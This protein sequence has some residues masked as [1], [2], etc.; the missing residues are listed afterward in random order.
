M[1]ESDLDDVSLDP[2]PQQPSSKTFG[3]G[4]RQPL[5]ELKPPREALEGPSA[6]LVKLRNRVTNGSG[7]ADFLQAADFSVFSGIE[8]VLCAT[9]LKKLV[10]ECNILIST[11]MPH[12]ITQ[13]A[14]VFLN[15]FSLMHRD[16]LM[17]NYTSWPLLSDLQPVFALRQE[18]ASSL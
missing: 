18:V 8:S 5:P 7:T 2:L 6:T 14:Q 15:G 4:K 16:W 3:R 9:L 10:S 11:R 1:I 13:A 12:L 17:L